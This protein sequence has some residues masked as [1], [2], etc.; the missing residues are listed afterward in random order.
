MNGPGWPLAAAVSAAGAVLV[1]GRAGTRLADLRPTDAAGTVRPSRPALA[2]LQRFRERSRRG[3]T[4]DA[5]WRA[6]HSV[7]A[8]LALELRS[9]HDLPSS[10]TAVAFEHRQLV[11]V[12]ARLSRAAAAAEAGADPAAELL[13]P[14]QSG[15]QRTGGPP[16]D[17]RRSQMRSPVGSADP[18]AGGYAWVTAA[19]RP[20][21][22]CLSVGHR[23]GLPLADLLESVASAA[24]G[25]AEVIELARVELA[26]ATASSWLLAG[27]PLAG[28]ALGQLI[29]AH[30]ARFLVATGAG[31]LCLAGAACLTAAGWL[32][33]RALTRRLHRELTP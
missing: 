9:G 26:G 22:S 2:A 14:R 11:E 28:L 23:A 18:S 1:T 33:M 12:A 13:G 4:G 25:A 7:P 6:G 29:G 15:R 21:A 27:L 5:Q 24:S 10:L 20:T 19:L 8:A 32:W 3:A 31:R 17:K 16:P 30:P